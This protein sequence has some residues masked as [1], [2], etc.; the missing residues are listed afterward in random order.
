MFYK[1]SWQ[2]WNGS[3]RWSKESWNQ[4]KTNI[5]D[6]TI[7]LLITATINRRVGEFLGNVL[8]IIKYVRGYF[9]TELQVSSPLYN[10]TRKSTLHKNNAKTI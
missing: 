10:S 2:K 3:T 1:K 7:N 9:A 8:I 4:L 6:I 5:S